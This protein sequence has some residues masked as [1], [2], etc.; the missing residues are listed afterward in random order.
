ME[1]TIYSDGGADPNP[2]IG[3]WAAILRYGKREKVLTGNDPHTTN[4][5]MELTAAVEALK[6]LNRPCR[7]Q[8]YTDSEYLRRGITEWIETWVKL[9]WRTQGKK[10]VANKDL[11]RELLPLTETHD[12]EWHWVR[13][14]SGDPLNERVDDLARQAR[15]E[16][17]PKIKVSPDAPRAYVRASYKGSTRTGGWGIVVEFDGE[18]RQFSGSEPNATNNRME[19]RA[20]IEGLKQLPEG[21]E[22]QL[23]TTSDY[24]YQGATKWIEGWRRRNWQKRDGKTIANDDLWRELDRLMS[25]YRVQWIG[26]KGDTGSD[27]RGLQEASRLAHEATEIV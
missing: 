15:E 10:P 4:N 12:I 7:V 17:S 11:W 23:V 20:A 24:V 22:V 18:T 19:I 21:S 25:Q 5:R 14:H 6:A 9:N 16:I 2:G 1:V 13:G 26:A 27:L 3:G 8:F